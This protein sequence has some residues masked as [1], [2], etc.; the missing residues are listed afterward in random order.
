M[1]DLVMRGEGLAGIWPEW[2][3]LL[4]FAAV[5]FLIGVRRFRYEQD[6]NWR[7]ETGGHSL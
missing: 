2:A 5:F 3:V 7:L 4:G 1:T 6:G